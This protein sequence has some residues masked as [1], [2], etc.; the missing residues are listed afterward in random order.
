MS[1]IDNNSTFIA[2]VLKVTAS[3]DLV[4]DVQKDLNQPETKT[5]AELLENNCSN[6]KKE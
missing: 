6:E 4:L 1:N 2:S 3:T 5:I